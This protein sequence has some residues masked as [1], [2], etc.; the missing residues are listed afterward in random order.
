MASD[1]KDACR[2]IFVSAR[3]RPLKASAYVAL[4]GGAWASF[5]TK[6]DRCSF[7]TELLERCNQLGLLSPWIRSPTSD[8][9]VQ[10]LVKL[11]N[12]GRLRHV[13]LGL[14]SLVF[15]YDH[16]PDVALYEAQ[17]SNLS[18]PWKE[19]PERLLDVGFAGR[20]WILDSKM[21]DYDVND[22]EFRRLPEHM[23][24]T[25]VPSVS[26]VE[27]NQRLHQESW[28]AV[29]TEE[30]GES[31][32]ADSGARQSVVEESTAQQEQAGA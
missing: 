27:R 25:S 23:Q 17:C 31:A 16:D 22:E 9:H 24:A 2:D 14:F 5:Q 7:E 18:V 19:L 29:K 30:E 3:E 1:Y 28:V 15:R 12:E 8:G 20:W 10:S 21:S 11:R 32:A 13:S 6:P 26:E 4:V